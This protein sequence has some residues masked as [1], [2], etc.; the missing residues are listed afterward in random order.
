MSGNL[1]ISR[2]TGESFYVGEAKVTLL[3]IGRYTTKISIQA[4]HSVAVDREEV[5]MAKIESGDYV[6]LED[7]DHWRD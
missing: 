4:P 1:I 6:P 5:R 2:K 3:D 7:I